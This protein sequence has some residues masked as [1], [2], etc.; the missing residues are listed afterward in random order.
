[1]STSAFAADRTAPVASFGRL[2]T[3]SPGMLGR[4]VG[5]F[6]RWQTRRLEHKIEMIQPRTCLLR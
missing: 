1:M 4:L 2:S 6:V 3:S 5:A